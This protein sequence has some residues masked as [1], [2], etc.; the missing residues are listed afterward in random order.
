MKEPLQTQMD[1]IVDFN[2]LFQTIFTK[3]NSMN[4]QTIDKKYVQG[5]STE[6][7]PKF[8][9]NI[10]ANNRTKIAVK[11]MRVLC[12]KYSLD[13]KWT[14][15]KP[16]N[17]ASNPV[18]RCDF[19]P[20]YTKEITAKHIIENIYL[21]ILGLDLMDINLTVMVN[22]KLICNHLSKS[23]SISIPYRVSTNFRFYKSRTKHYY[24]E[25]IFT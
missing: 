17:I 18:P 1:Y 13:T 15:C 24:R 8:I 12:P 11:S 2:R 9:A 4:L 20:I 10:D 19:S 16:L 3:K 5:K 23:S 25:G 22:N 21:Y 6:K 14:L 7:S